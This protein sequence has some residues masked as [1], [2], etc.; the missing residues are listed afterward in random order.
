VGT[1]HADTTRFEWTANIHRDSYASYIGH[2][3]LLS[4]LAL[5]M[6]EAR[7]IVRAKMI[8]KMVRPVGAPPEVQD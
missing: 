3:P 8:E 4:Y 6:G 7:E 2:P 1:G 5:G